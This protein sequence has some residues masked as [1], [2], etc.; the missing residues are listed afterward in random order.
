MMDLDLDVFESW[1]QCLDHTKITPLLNLNHKCQ[2][3]KLYLQ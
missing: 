3:L 1:A 2:D